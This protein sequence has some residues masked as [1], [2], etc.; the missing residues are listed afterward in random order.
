ML[1]VSSRISTDHLI[2]I[3]ND[4]RS[5]SLPRQ[6]EELYRR[7]FEMNCYVAGMGD[8]TC[9][10]LV[11]LTMQDTCK[12]LQQM[13]QRIESESPASDCASFD[14]QEPLARSGRYPILN[15]MV[16]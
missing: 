11:R 6:Y 4:P 12:Q 7:Y 9:T 1:A 2:D 10:G 5:K 16:G 3:M 13:R 8:S 15:Y 14:R